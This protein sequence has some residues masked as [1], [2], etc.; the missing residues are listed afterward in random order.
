VR[1]GPRAIPG[2]AP[3]GGATGEAVRAAAAANAGPSTPPAG[4]AAEAS[5]FDSIL[6]L[7]GAA[8]PAA[9]PAAAFA[10][11]APTVAEVETLPADAEGGHG[12]P[13]RKDDASAG[14]P[15]T[16]P[17][18]VTPGLPFVPTT[19][20]AVGAPAPPA[21][22]SSAAPVPPPITGVQSTSTHAFSSAASAAP[23]TAVA[24]S[25]R[26]PVAATDGPGRGGYPAVT[27]TGETPTAALTPAPS[28]A[29]APAATPGRHACDSRSGG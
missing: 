11:P 23:E 29:A 12:A 2:F 17:L 20:P 14:E 21:T 27:S 8:S 9:S 25:A 16:F 1:T 6:S 13:S 28:A 7:L 26:A 19:T 22:I 10:V 5:S 4:G 3:P 24:F 15:E 18:A